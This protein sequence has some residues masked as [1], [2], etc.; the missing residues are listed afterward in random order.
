MA[1]DLCPAA[2]KVAR[3]L[4]ALT[5]NK[6]YCIILVKDK[7]GNWQLA[8]LSEAKLEAVGS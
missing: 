2:V 1:E 8:I 4:Q 5:K 3:R 6:L 7:Y